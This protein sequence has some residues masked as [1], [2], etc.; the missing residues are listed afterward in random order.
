MLAFQ[1]SLG[2]HSPNLQS[3]R[4]RLESEF[5]ILPLQGLGNNR[6]SPLGE[7]PRLLGGAGGVGRKLAEGKEQVLLCGGAS[8]KDGEGGVGRDWTR[9]GGAERRGPLHP[10]RVAERT[11]DRG[12]CGGLL[13]AGTQQWKH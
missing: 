1:G 12:V 4:A 3:R 2:I 7:L 11:T 5:Q 6:A 8:R 9:W 10:E 13:E